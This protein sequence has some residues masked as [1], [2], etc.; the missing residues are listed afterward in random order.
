PGQCRLRCAGP[1]IWRAANRPGRD[2]RVREHKGRSRLA[3]ARRDA[4]LQPVRVL[5]NA[6]QGAAAQPEAPG[7]PRAVRNPG[8]FLERGRVTVIRRWDPG[9]CKPPAKCPREDFRWKSFTSCMTPGAVC[10]VGPSA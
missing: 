1:E 7:A 8:P 2:H 9:I 10:A 3:G 5:E 6:P 4:F